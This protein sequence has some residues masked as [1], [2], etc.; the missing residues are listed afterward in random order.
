[1][2]KKDEEC[3]MCHDLGRI[4]ICPECC[5]NPREA[6][7]KFFKAREPTLEN[8]LKKYKRWAT[9]CPTSGMVQLPG[10]YP[11]PWCDS[12][13]VE[14]EDINMLNTS[15]YLVVCKKD[16]SHKFLWIPWGG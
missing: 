3:P 6:D 2:S 15:G 1:M 13:V 4:P 14:K 5:L 12:E 7:E 8:I 9:K 16:S 11:C 10:R